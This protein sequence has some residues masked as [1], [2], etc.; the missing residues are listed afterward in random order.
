M[1]I[2]HTTT[3]V[4]L[5]DHHTLFRDGVRSILQA[6]QNIRV[7][8]EAA[9]GTTAVEVAPRARPDVILL[10]VDTGG[11]HVT[12][13]VRRVRETVPHCHVIVLTMHDDAQ[14]LSELLGLG[15]RGYLLKTVGWKDLVAAVS[16]VVTDPDRVVLSVSP[17]TVA[18]AHTPQVNP[19]SSR[20][21]EI[22]QLTSHAMSNA[23]IANRLSLTEATVKRHLHNVFR[24]LN[25]VSRL[26]AVNKAR[27][28]GLLSSAP[29]IAA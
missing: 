2:D 20:E 1:T 3:N 14:L 9:N 17:S 10:D 6:N 25:A 19:L 12:T 13:V 29:A 23:Q 11:T 8:A 22:L 4:M 27:A 24:K 15:I 21:S 26:D 16:S 7:V 18:R 5:V 28:A